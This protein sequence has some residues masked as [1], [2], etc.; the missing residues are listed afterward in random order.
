[1]Q[2]LQEFQSKCSSK[3]CTVQLSCKKNERFIAARKMKSKNSLN[4]RC[5]W[6]ILHK[7][8]LFSDNIIFMSVIPQAMTLP[9]LHRLYMQ[10]CL[11]RYLQHYSQKWYHSSALWGSLVSMRKNMHSKPEYFMYAK[12]ISWT[13]RQEYF[14][15]VHVCVSVCRELLCSKTLVN[16]Y[17][18][19][20]FGI[21]VFWIC[22]AE[23]E[24]YWY[25]AALK[26]KNFKTMFSTTWQLQVSAPS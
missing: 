11:P 26:K 3:S 8:G 4:M 18:D 9:F 23:Q 15:H 16:S 12:K 22:Y 17:T 5:M 19:K 14:M 1:M 25:D 13:L 21:L 6:K 7:F 2:Q 20:Q 24:G 10:F